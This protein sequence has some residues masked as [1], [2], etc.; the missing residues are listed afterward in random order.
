MN[1]EVHDLGLLVTLK[2]LYQRSRR[3]LKASIGKD[4]LIGKDLTIPSRRLGQDRGDWVV[5]DRMIFSSSIV[6]SVGIGED[7]SFDLALIRRYGCKVYVWDPTP[8]AVNFIAGLKPPAGFSFLPYGLGAED[9]VKQFGAQD[10]GDHSYS[11]L[12]SHPVK[13]SLQVRKL[14]SMMKLLN[15]DRV[16][17]LKMDIVGDEYDVICQ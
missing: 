13:E 4:H 15:H 16:D 8:L 10:G 9:S 14:T 17:I 12:S 3:L 1:G 5:A 11:S 2:H 6:Y 7:I